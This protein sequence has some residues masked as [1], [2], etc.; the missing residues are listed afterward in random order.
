MKEYIGKKYYETLGV[1]S[2]ATVE[3][4]KTAYRKLAR[5]YHPDLNPGNKASEQKFKEITEAYNVLISTTE[6][7]KYDTINGYNINTKTSQQQ[8]NSKTASTQSSY[9]NKRNAKQAYSNTQ[10]KEEPPKEFNTVFSE[11]MDGLFSSTKNKKQQTPPPKKESP[12]P[13][14]GS[15]ITVDVNISPDESINGT[16]KQINVLYVSECPKCHGKT[17]INGSTCSF[18]NGNGEISTHNKIKVKIPQNVKENSK[19]RIPNEGNRGQNGGDNGDLF[20][21]VHIIKNSIL[22]YDGLNILCTIPITPPEAALGASIE[23]PTKDGVLTM[24]IPPGTSSGQK[25]KLASEGLRDEKTKQTGDQI[26]T[27]EIVMTK[28]LSSEEKELYQK[29]LKAQKINPRGDLLKS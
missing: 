17:F 29:L 15:D 19:I 12:K 13:I 28:D 25:F 21:I 27:V 24:K 26:V 9:Q 2:S 4:I 16:V 23:I 5:K 18:C 1:Q 8:Q 22:K 14:K 20:L 11:F 7:A 3:E 10:K 6:R